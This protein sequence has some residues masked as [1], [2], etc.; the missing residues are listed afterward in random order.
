[1]STQG[2]DRVGL[3]LALAALIFAACAGAAMIVAVALH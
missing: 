1:M 2:T 3:V